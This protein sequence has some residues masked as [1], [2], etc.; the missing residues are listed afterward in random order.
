MYV[1]GRDKFFRPIII[2]DVTKFDFKRYHIDEYIE[3]TIFLTMFVIEKLLIKGKVEN[4]LNFT[5]MDHQGIS[6]LPI[7]AIMKM[8]QVA[9]KVFKCR[10][11]QSF[12]LNPPSS[13]YYIWT[14]CKPFID[15]ATQAK[16]HIEKNLLS[17]EMFNIIDPSQ[18]EQKYGGTAVNAE[19]YWPPFF[20]ESVVF[21]SFDTAR[22]KASTPDSEPE[23]SELNCQKEEKKLEFNQNLCEK[24]KKNSEIFENFSNEKEEIPVVKHKK[25]HK[26]SKDSE[27]L[28]ALIFEGKDAEI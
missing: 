1:F 19:K 14:C 10:L 11:A 9:Q 5:N 13:I 27:E 17:P 7:K 22:S 26:K 23:I 16:V 20:P 8:T 15:K 6:Q 18:V 24:K 4:W 3:A 28:K 12:V 21:E 25:K 2:L